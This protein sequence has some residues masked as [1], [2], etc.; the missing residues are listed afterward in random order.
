MGMCDSSRMY[1]LTGNEDVTHQEWG[2]DS[3]GMHVR[4][5]NARSLYKVGTFFVCGTIALFTVT[6]SSKFFIE[7]SKLLMKPE[8]AQQNKSFLNQDFVSIT[9]R[10]EIIGFQN[11]YFSIVFI[12]WLAFF[13]NQYT[14]SIEK[15]KLFRLIAAKQMKTDMLCM[16][17]KSLNYELRC[18]FRFQCQFNFSH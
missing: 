18:F 9:F 8:R 2:C 10:L 14:K 11:F 4:T 17:K 12:L 7:I 5:R 15:H 16:S 13:A 6:S 3:P 1:L